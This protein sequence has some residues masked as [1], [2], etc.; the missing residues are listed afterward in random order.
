M[1]V[2]MEGTTTN[3]VNKKLDEL[4][5]EAGVDHDGPGR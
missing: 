2:D 5:E 1:I 3:A 4:R